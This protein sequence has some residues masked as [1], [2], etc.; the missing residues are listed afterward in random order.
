MNEQQDESLKKK[1]LHTLLA[2]VLW[3]LISGLGI[4]LLPQ[5][6]NTFTRIYTTLFL[7]ADPFAARGYWAA[8]FFRSVIVIFLGLLLLGTTIGSAEYLF[9][10]PGKPRSWTPIYRIAAVECAL[11]V[12]T[13][14]I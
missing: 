3:L 11:I 8:T 12:L 1:M 2:L 7:E 14:F 5:M 10:H 9:R 13:L 4:V 6:L